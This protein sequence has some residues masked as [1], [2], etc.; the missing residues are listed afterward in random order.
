MKQEFHFKITVHSAG[1]S[2]IE[3]NGRIDDHKLIEALA[4][5]LRGHTRFKEC[6]GRALMHS[7]TPGS[8]NGITIMDASTSN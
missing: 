7:M 5:M 2:E 3:I 8:E 6:I 1:V 4:A